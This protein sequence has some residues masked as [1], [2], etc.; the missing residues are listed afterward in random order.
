[1]ANMLMEKQMQY[2]ESGSSVQLITEEEW[3]MMQDLPMK[4]YMLERMGIQRQRD[5]IE[6]DPDEVDKEMKENALNIMEKF[7]KEWSG[8]ADDG[9]E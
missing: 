2:Q 5:S 3:L 7:N 9:E 6:E 8:L 4:E 1:M